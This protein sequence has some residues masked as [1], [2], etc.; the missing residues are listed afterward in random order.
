LKFGKTAVRLFLSL[1]LAALATAALVVDFS[2]T[3]LTVDGKTHIHYAL[4]K[5]T[6]REMLDRYEVKIGTSDIVQPAPEDRLGWRDR[7]RVIRVTEKVEEKAEETPFV[8]EW[9]RRSSRN[10]RKVEV[11]H[12][13]S[14]RKLWEIRTVFHDGK[15]VQTQ[16]TLKRSEPL[17]VDRLVFLDDNGFPGQTYDLSKAQKIRVVATAYWVG[18]PKVP[19]TITFTG[20]K[21]ERGLVAVDP[22]VIPLGYRLY[23]PGYGYAYSADTGSAIKG[24]RIDLFVENKKVSRPW[25]YVKVDVYL[26]EKA[27]S[28]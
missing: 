8:L 28:W 3:L 20:R 4:K 19:G 14:D 27:P 18:D 11:Q 12:G 23:I 26:L 13:R 2:K 9:K 1:G 16:K 15:A 22:K 5:G 7:I 17:A 6:V 25:E 21:V 10:L 24:K